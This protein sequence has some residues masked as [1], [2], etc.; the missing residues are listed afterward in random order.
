MAFTT[1][2]IALRCQA[3]SIAHQ[4][5]GTRYKEIGISIKATALWEERNRHQD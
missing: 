5:I 3:I 1:K 2:E 4:E